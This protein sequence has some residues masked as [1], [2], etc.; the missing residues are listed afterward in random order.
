MLTIALAAN[1]HCPVLRDLRAL[2]PVRHVAWAAV[3]LR[4]D[5]HV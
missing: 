3:V 4:H 2:W 5:S 1:V